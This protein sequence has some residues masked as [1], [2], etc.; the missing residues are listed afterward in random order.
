MWP[1]QVAERVERRF[2][3]LV[4]PGVS[5]TRAGR[6]V[7]ERRFTVE[8]RADSGRR[9]AVGYAAVFDAPY[10]VAGGPEHG[11]WMETV[12]AGSCT[13]TLRERDP[14]P[15][16]V[17]HDSTS[18]WGLPLAATWADTLRLS[19]DQTG[20]RVE[21]EIGDDLLSQFL[22]ERLSRG[23]ADSM[24]IAFRVINDAWDERYEQRI[25]RELA[26]HDV[27]VVTYPAN[28]ATSVWIRSGDVSDDADDAG[29]ADDAGVVAD[30][31]GDVDDDAGDVSDA[32]GV[33]D[34]DDG[35]ASSSV[36]AKV[37]SAKLML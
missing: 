24:S 10:S 9:M 29:N 37:A 28:P 6:V 2:G 18:A 14:V 27:S 12:A 7:D 17:N 13:K 20:L 5:T 11:G 19:A 15:L 33:P 26:L 21:A 31:A 34:A 32:G 22:A 16:L 35:H 30:D 1:E 3:G 4:V 8:M 36:F 23:E 25:I